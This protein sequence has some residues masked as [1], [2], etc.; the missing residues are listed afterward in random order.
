LATAR[1]RSAVTAADIGQNF[2]IGTVPATKTWI[3]KEVLVFFTNKVTGLL[4]S[5]VSVYHLPSGVTD[6]AVTA[7]ASFLIGNRLTQA[8]DIAKLIQVIA[9]GLSATANTVTILARNTILAAGDAIKLSIQ[10]A[11]AGSFA[12]DDVVIAVIVSGDET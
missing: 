12:A 11:A 8:G 3:I 6:F 9:S 5:G 7:A 1:I 2:V 4:A 10:P